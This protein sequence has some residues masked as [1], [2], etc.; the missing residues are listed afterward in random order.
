MDELKTSERVIKYI[1]SYFYPNN[2][3]VQEVWIV[4]EY[5]K[6][7]TLHDIIKTN[8]TEIQI[9]TVVK[10]CVLALDYAHSKNIIHR[11]I[12]SENVLV[13]MNGDIKLCGLYLY[14]T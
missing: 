8:L 7:S 2:T 4:M 14:H 9:A 13:G 11:D 6:G 12:H 5:V 10:E 1:E 3:D